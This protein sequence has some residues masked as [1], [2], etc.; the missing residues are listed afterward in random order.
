MRSWVI[1]SLTQLKSVA[2]KLSRRHMGETRAPL[3]TMARVLI[4]E[5]ERLLVFYRR[6]YDRV[7]GKVLE[8]YSFPGGSVEPGES[9]E[10]A[11]VREAREEMGIDIALGPKVAIQTS[12]GYVNHTFQASIVAGTPVLQEDSEEAYYMHEGNHYEVRWV[13]VHDLS[14]DKL[15]Y[16]GDFLP[17]LKLMIA[18]HDFRTPMQIGESAIVEEVKKGGVNGDQN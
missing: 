12:N 9:I 13:S 5:D 7:A 18:R 10:A 8:Y 11:A 17:V 16:Y 15:L 1:S 14:A 4:I 2:R 6:R 3:R